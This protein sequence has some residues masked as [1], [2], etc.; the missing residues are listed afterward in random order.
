MKN[1]SIVDRLKR[2][3]ADQA[4]ETEHSASSE[5]ILTPKTEESMEL[6]TYRPSV[7]AHLRAMTKSDGEGGIAAQIQSWRARVEADKIKQT[8]ALEM[9]KDHVDAARQENRVL[10]DARITESAERIKTLIKKELN[11]ME[12]VRMEN[13]ISAL[14][15]AMEIVNRKL[16]EIENMEVMKPLKDKLQHQAYE[17]YEAACERIRKD[18][19]MNKYSSKF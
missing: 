15:K 6:E 11:E 3:M 18:V 14:V 5:L 19:L 9:L 2:F 17:Q 16:M 4:R 1:E 7:L 12:S 8:G 10:L 13:E